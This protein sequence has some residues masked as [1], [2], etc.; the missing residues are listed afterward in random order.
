MEALRASA[1]HAAATGEERGF[2]KRI[3]GDFPAFGKSF[4]DLADDEYNIITSISMERLHGLNWVCAIHGLDW[5][6]V[7]LNT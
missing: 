5:D 4:R 1:D 6:D 7:E 3:N 2:F